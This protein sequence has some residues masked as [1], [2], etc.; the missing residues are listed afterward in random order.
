M[1]QACGST[2]DALGNSDQP[3]S[4]PRGS[5]YPQKSIQAQAS[6]Y[7]LT[8]NPRNAGGLLGSGSER[9]AQVGQGQGLPGLYT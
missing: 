8:N 3:L 4:Q 2:W 9:V 1:P 5:C 6:L 7:L